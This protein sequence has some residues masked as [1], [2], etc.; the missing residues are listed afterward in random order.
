MAGNDKLFELI[1]SLNEGEKSWL[2]KCFKAFK[3][4]NNLKLF[5]YLEASD[6]YDKKQIL[7]AL[8]KAP[9]VN[10]LPVQKSNLYN[11]ILKFLK[12]YSAEDESENQLGKEIFDIN[13]LDERLLHQPSK[14]QITELKNKADQQ[15]EHYQLLHLLGMELDQAADGMQND[16][17]RNT[18]ENIYQSYCNR[19]DLL[20]EIWDYKYWVSKINLMRQNPALVPDVNELVDKI[21]HFIHDQVPPKHPVARYYFNQIT[22]FYNLHVENFSNALS[23]TEEQI[24]Y[25]DNLKVPTVKQQNEK[26]MTHINGISLAFLTDVDD[27]KMEE[28]IQKTH[29]LLGDEVFLPFH[30]VLYNKLYY[31]QLNHYNFNDSMVPREKLVGEILSKNGQQNFEISPNLSLSLA[32]Y[33]FDQKNYDSAI[34]WNNNTINTPKNQLLPLVQYNAKVLKVLIHLEKGDVFFIK[35]ILDSLKRFLQNNDFENN[36][37]N[38]VYLFLKKYEEELM[39][40][41]PNT[42]M[43]CKQFYDSIADQRLEA[44]KNLRF[45]DIAGWLKKNKL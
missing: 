40:A 36:F 19:L 13:Y 14:D 28:I 17:D 37:N 38:S 23:I 18:L 22:L 41:Y 21:E 6:R 43:L 12:S 24:D 16:E 39:S 27:Q 4:K 1:K 7:I 26:A 10:Y 33:Y 11:A 31:N 5:N 3:Q 2:V 34:N 32:Y 45:V 29:D 44:K 8:R 30:D 20:K 35:S 25:L 15:H 42:R 9:F